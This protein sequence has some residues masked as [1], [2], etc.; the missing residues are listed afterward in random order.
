[1]NSEKIL[2]TGANGFTAGHFLDFLR[3]SGVSEDRIFGADREAG[4]SSVRWRHFIKADFLDKKQVLNMLRKVK[5]GLIFH[6]AGLNFG[7]DHNELLRSNVFTTNNLLEALVKI[8]LKSRVLI[9]GSSAE[10][11]IAGGSKDPIDETTPLAPI[12]PYGISKAVQTTLALRYYSSFGLYIVIARSFNLT[13]PGQSTD[14]VCGSIVSQVKAICTGKAKT[15]KLILGNTDTERDFIDVRDAVSAYWQL[16]TSE[17]NIAGQVFNV[18]SGKSNSIRHV[19]EILFKYCGRKIRLEQRKDKVRQNDIP[20]QV[21][22]ITKIKTAVIGWKSTID[23]ERSL[24][25]MYE[26]IV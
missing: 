22:D 1:M 7:S 19:T 20:T 8:G 12:T 11:G 23:I 15:D 24:I 13:G 10:Y 21:A 26:S 2:I 17:K 6:F 4:L 18:G 3:L 16:L 14:L 25:D 5:P 9:V